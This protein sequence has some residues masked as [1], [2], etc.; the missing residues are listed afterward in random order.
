MYF[1]A[2]YNNEHLRR[3]NV[4]TCII[5]LFITILL[6]IKNYWPPNDIAF[7][8]TDIV[9]PYFSIYLVQE[10]MNVIHPLRKEKTPCKT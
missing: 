7:L 5:V 9:I 10:L 6:L 3:M 4:L 2:S 1:H 8:Y